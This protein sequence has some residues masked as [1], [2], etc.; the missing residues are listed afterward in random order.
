MQYIIW[1]ISI[2]LL[3]ILLFRIAQITE[4]DEFINIKGA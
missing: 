3:Y 1:V 2:Q 4:K